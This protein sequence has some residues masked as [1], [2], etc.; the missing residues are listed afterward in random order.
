MNVQVHPSLNA[1][2]HIV[3]T[4]FNVGVITIKSISD[5]LHSLIHGIDFLSRHR[6]TSLPILLARKPCAQLIL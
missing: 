6:R 4:P 3:R 2:G 5:E 1:A